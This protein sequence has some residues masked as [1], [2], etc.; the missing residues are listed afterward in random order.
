M[1]MKRVKRCVAKW[2][3]ELSDKLHNDLVF[4]AAIVTRDK[5]SEKNKDSKFSSTPPQLQV[6]MLKLK[7]I[8]RPQ[9]QSSIIVQTLIKATVQRHVMSLGFLRLGGISQVID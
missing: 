1:T 9:T 5:N 6:L 7:L 8:E 4:C 3:P 2:S